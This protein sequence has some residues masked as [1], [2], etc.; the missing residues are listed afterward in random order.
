MSAAGPVM[1]ALPV[2]LKEH[3]LFRPQSV[4][5]KSGAGQMVGLFQGLTATKYI[6][7]TTF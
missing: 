7:D 5:F 1:S 4:R 3:I 2:F 6:L